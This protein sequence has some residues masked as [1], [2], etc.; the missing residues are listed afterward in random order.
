MRQ[1]QQATTPP[2]PVPL[3]WREAARRNHIAL[4]YMVTVGGNHV[5]HPVP[6]VDLRHRRKS[7]AYRPVTP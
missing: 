7:R 4:A 1:G 3:T 5:T 6:G 2:A